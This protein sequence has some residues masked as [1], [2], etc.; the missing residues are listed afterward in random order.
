MNSD[1]KIEMFG[2]VVDRGYKSVLTALYG[3]WVQGGVGGVQRLV[4]G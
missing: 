4:S 2:Y 1:L 3:F